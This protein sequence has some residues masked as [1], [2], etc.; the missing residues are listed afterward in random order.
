M[1]KKSDL[2]TLTL[3]TNIMDEKFKGDDEE[4]YLD[5][6]DNGV[7]KIEDED[8]NKLFYKLRFFT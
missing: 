5:A 7:I 6:K 1:E 2:L 4:R 8:V 3:E